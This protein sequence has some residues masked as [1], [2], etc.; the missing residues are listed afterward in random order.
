[1]KN[2]ENFMK[3]NGIKAYRFENQAI[4]TEISESNTDWMVFTPDIIQ[5]VFKVLLNNNNYNLL[6]IDKTNV[7]IGLLRKVCKWNYSSLISEYR[8]YSGKNSNYFSET[9][10]ELATITLSSNAQGQRRL[11]HDMTDRPPLIARASSRRF[12]E[13][14]MEVDDDDIDNEENLLSASPKVPKALLKMAELRKKSKM[15]SDEA[16]ESPSHTKNVTVNA[17]GTF[18]GAWAQHDGFKFYTAGRVFK[19]V[20]T[21]NVE[22]PPENQLPEWFIVQRQ[23]WDAGL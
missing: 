21:I 7:M 5:K 3:L 6:V 18:P 2:F 12:S 23:M 4:N 20:E 17:E 10:L 13:D 15:S 9:F 8:L 16:S 22:L 1:M 11:T 14:A 19:N